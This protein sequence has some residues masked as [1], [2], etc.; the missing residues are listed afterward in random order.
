MASDVKELNPPIDITIG[1]SK[2]KSYTAPDN[3]G[4]PSYDL[5]AGS[6]YK[7]TGMS[8]K[9]QNWLR[10]EIKTTGDGGQPKYDSRWVYAGQDDE[11]N[12]LL[13]GTSVQDKTRLR[14]IATELASEIGEGVAENTYTEQELD[15]MLATTNAATEIRD[16]NSGYNDEYV[17]L[18]ANN[19]QQNLDALYEHYLLLAVKAYGAPPQATPYA[20]PRIIK[21]NTDFG[22]D[23][24]IGRKFAEVIVS[25]PTIL[26]LCPGVIKY[27]SILAGT[28]AAGDEDSIVESAKQALSSD[29]NGKICEFQPCWYSSVKDQSGYI[30]FV[31][32][33][34]WVSAIA[35]S[36]QKINDDD[37]RS[38]A[39]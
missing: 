12:P 38:L 30:K 22:P 10:V 15:D 35:M 31:N 25:N 24:L 6:S 7:V 16:I 5:L 29:K 39:E 2:L 9:D 21:L 18:Y 17:V 32:T 27:N 36:R 26:S 11:G 3:T 23:I 37:A 33:L 1:D 19:N 34:N 20:D 14:N 4:S 28:F 13:E 8:S